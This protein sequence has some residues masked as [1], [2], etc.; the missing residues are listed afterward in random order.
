MKKNGGK[1]KEFFTKLRQIYPRPIATGTKSE[2]SLADND[3]PCIKSTGRPISNKTALQGRLVIKG[4]M[5]AFLFTV[6]ILAGLVW[7]TW[8]SNRHL[9]MLE[10]THFR[11]L[12][13]SGQ[14]CTS[15]KSLLCQHTWQ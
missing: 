10:M 4:F 13:L 1:A 3:N 12:Q 15:T 8:R 9:K 11:L 5:L 6:V 7:Y 14:I 2:G